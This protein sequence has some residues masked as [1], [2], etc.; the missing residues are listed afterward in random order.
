MNQSPP[1]AA[2]KGPGQSVLA[3]VRGRTEPPCFGPGALHCDHG[4]LR[5]GLDGQV[6][7]LR[8]STHPVQVLVRRPALTL[9][10]SGSDLRSVAQVDDQVVDDP[11]V[12]VQHATVEGLAAGF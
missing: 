10:C 11:A 2:K 7:A 12:G 9:A 6:L 3:Q 8:L 4:E 1:S 5:A